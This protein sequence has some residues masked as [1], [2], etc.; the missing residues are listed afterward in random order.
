MSQYDSSSGKMI[1]KRLF[2]S[3]TVED[4]AHIF[5]SQGPEFSVILLGLFAHITGKQNFKSFSQ[6]MQFQGNTVAL[7]ARQF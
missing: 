6:E 3:D 4:L 5:R 7:V 1:L 2:L